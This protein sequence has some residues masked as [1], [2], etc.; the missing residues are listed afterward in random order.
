[1]GN[2]PAAFWIRTHRLMSVSTMSC[3][4]FLHLQYW[5]LPWSL[6]YLTKIAYHFLFLIF[7][8]HQT[9]ELLRRNISSA[10]PV[11]ICISHCS[12]VNHWPQLTVTLLSSCSLY[13]GCSLV[14]DPSLTFVWLSDMGTFICGYP[15]EPVNIQMTKM[16]IETSPFMP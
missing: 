2:A 10:M 9:F 6:T 15:I 16:K 13:C 12:W 4:P 3:L 11:I 8:S 5:F 7:A 1:M 14:S